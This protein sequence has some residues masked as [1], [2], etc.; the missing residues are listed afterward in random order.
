MKP[1]KNYVLVAEAKVE[2][3]TASGLILTTDVETGSK[4]GIVLEVGVDTVAVR[5]G[6]KVAFNWAKGL[7]VTVDGVKSV[8]V[9]EDEILGIY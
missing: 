8:L 3:K 6:D 9:S 2:N 7:P 5:K 4:P 1:L